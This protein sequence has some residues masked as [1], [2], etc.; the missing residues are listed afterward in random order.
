MFSALLAVLTGELRAAIRR[1][2]AVGAG[3]A[4]ALA[5]LMFAIGFGLV[6]LRDWLSVAFDTNNAN[7]FLAGGLALIAIIVASASA[8][9]NRAPRKSPVMPVV[10]MVAAP[11]AA[12]VALRALSPQM[13][14]TGAVVLGGVLL[15]RSLAKPK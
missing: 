8:L 1:K 15:G 14:A 6:A 4:V 2:T 13:I 12:K 11:A 7:A 10:A 9:A 5:V 3:Y